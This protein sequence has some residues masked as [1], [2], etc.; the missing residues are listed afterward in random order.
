MFLVTSRTW[1]LM[2]ASQVFLCTSCKTRSVSS[3]RYGLLGFKAVYF[4]ESLLGITERCSRKFRTLRRDPK[5][6]TVFLLRH[7]G[8]GSA[9]LTRDQKK[10][11]WPESSSELYRPSDRR[12]SAMLVPTFADR[13]VSHHY[14]RILG[15]LVRSSYCFF[16]VAPQLYSQGWV[17]SVPDPLLLINSGSA[18]NRTP[19]LWVCSQ[20]L[21][22]LDHIGSQLEIQISLIGAIPRQSAV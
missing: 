13:G 15:F 7:D 17:D 19:F 1:Q 12:I 9:V 8:S 10:K 14:R 5:I 11:L 4:G 22:P 21:W 3:W 2:I 6:V 18:G 20:E 16:E